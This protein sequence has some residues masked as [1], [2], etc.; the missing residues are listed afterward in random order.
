MDVLVM[1]G[2][3]FV[4]YHLVWRLL[5]G[6][7][8][9]T[10]VNRGTLG[11]PFGARVERLVADRT[12]AD[13]GALLGERRFD[14]AVDFAAYHPGDVRQVLAAL[15]GGRVGHYVFISTGQVYLVREPR[16]RPAREEDYDGALMP[17]PPDPRDK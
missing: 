14:A 8:R 13:L 2:T 3:R 10:L 12:T 16:P 5:A 17:E 9:V 6:G 4:G 11:D 7:H 1:G 15:G